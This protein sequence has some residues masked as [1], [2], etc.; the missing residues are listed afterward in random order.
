MCAIFGL[1]DY[2]KVFTAAQRE[3]FMNVLASESEIRGTD[4]TG[5]AFNSGGKL[6]IFK[7]PVAAHELSLR[8]S[9]DAN[10]ILGHTRMATQGDQKLNYNNHPFYGKARNTKFA[11]AHNGI[12]YNDDKLR[13]DLQI[14]ES[15]IETDSY[16]AVQIIEKSGELSKKSLA[17][18][19]EKIN[20]SFVFTLLDENNNSYFVRGDNPL[21]LYH[22]KEGFY[23]YASTDMILETTI[24]ELG[25]H[26]LQFEEIDSECGDILK[27]DSAGNLTRT[28]FQPSGNY[29]MDYGY[30]PMNRRFS[31]LDIPEEYIDLMLDYGYTLGEIADLC[32]IP[33]AV[34]T[35]VSEILCEYGHCDE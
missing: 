15:Y 22:F 14:S 33:R 3:C 34:E 4:A 35:T 20:G 19:A 23:V 10:V 2:K 28:A 12:I 31:R 11:L 24:V 1:I 5:F 18:M 30:I 9:E 17:K 7:R 13:R 32:G 21:A 16:I 8:L 25:L 26:D 27:I 29:C 6:K